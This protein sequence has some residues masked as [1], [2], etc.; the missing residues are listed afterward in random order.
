MVQLT[1]EQRIFIVVKYTQTQS[2]A[3]V[4]NA[5]EERFPQRNLFLNGSTTLRWILSQAR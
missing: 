5:F 3:A 2:I 4:Q 1:T